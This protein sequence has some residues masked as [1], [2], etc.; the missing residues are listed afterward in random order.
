MAI[1]GMI[2]EDLCS[3]PTVKVVKVVDGAKGD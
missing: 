1:L 3:S 2:C